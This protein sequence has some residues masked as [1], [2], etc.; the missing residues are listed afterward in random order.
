MLITAVAVEKLG[1]PENWLKTD[2]QKCIRIRRKSFIGHP[3]ATIFACA[4]GER[5]FQQPL[6]LPLTILQHR[7]SV[8]LLFELTCDGLVCAR[9]TPLPVV[10]TLA[11]SG[12][13]G[14]NLSEPQTASCG[15]RQACE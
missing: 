5:V 11:C 7:G 3:S 14:W 1:F 13:S 6:P 10:P 12:S 15:T 9:I 2:D 8:L 4:L